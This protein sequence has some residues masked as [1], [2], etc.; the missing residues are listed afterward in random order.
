MLTESGVI[1]IS[2]TEFKLLNSCG[3]FVISSVIAVNTVYKVLQK[4]FL[5]LSYLKNRTY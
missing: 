1:I 2:L 3:K 4:R 5:F